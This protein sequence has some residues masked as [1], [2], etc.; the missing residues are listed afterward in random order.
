MANKKELPV[1]KFSLSLPPESLTQLDAIAEALM[2]PP[3]VS[4][5][6]KIRMAIQYA[7]EQVMRHKKFM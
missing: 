6:M 4:R 1:E 5:S 3:R 2:L 7:Y